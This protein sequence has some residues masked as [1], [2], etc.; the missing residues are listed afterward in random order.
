LD[1][2]YDFN[3]SSTGA[4]YSLQY[5]AHVKIWQFVFAYGRITLSSNGSGVSAARIASFPF[6][7]A[8]GSSTPVGNYRIITGGSGD[9]GIRPLMEVGATTAESV[10][11]WRQA[12]R[13]R[14]TPIALIHSACTL[15]LVAKLRLSRE[16][17]FCFIFAPSLPG[18]FLQLRSRLSGK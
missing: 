13:W 7:S 18:L 17:S 4:T 1:A 10:I 12:I 8:G 16:N 5:G 2:G 15:L 14:R 9:A 6:I 11:T 3:N